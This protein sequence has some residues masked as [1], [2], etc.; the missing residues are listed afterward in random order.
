MDYPNVVVGY[1]IEGQTFHCPECA[2]DKHCP[3]YRINIGIYS[4]QCAVC[5]SLI[6]DGVKK[7]NRVDPLNLFDGGL[8]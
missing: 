6:V 3:V 5:K 8:S 4:Q 1:L 7:A 2:S